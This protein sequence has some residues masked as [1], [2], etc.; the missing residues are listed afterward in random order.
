MRAVF[1]THKA[2]FQPHIFRS[3]NALRFFKALRS[4]MVAGGLDPPIIAGFDKPYKAKDKDL[5]INWGVAHNAPQF[6]CDEIWNHPIGVARACNKIATLNLLE[7]G[8]FPVI[9]STTNSLEAFAWYATGNKVFVRNL[10]NGHGG[11]GIEV[12]SQTTHPNLTLE[13]FPEAPLYTL[14]FKKNSEFRYHIFEGGLITVQ[15]KKKMTEEKMLAA[16]ITFRPGVRNYH[17]GWAFCI[18]D[19]PVFDDI[20]GECIA[21]VHLLGLKFGAVDVLAMVTGGRLM[22]FA[23]CEVNTA[24]AIEAT[25]QEKYVETFYN[26]IKRLS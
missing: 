1:F 3:C 14:N 21:A 10:V 15:Q 17:N 16:G 26:E 5:V 20:V 8:G 22:N 25:T 19:V 18:Q 2:Y 9:D 11:E 13:D 7:A 6:D 24:P 23:I 12:I 4:R